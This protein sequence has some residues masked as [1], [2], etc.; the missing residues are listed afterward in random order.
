MSVYAANENGVQALKTMSNALYTAVEEIANHTTHIISITDEYC[1]TIG[2][3]KSSLDQA[4]EE[5]S[6]CIRRSGE[7]ANDIA[8]RLCEVAE[9]Y[10][11]VID[12]DRFNGRNGF[13]N[14]TVGVSNGG[15]FL[16]R[17]FGGSKNSSNVNKFG[18]FDTGKY[19]N[20]DSVVKGDNFEQYMSDYYD[21]EN[22]T[23]E[24]L[25]DN[26]VVETIPPSKIEGIHLGSTEM[27]DNGRFWSQH[28]SGGTADSFKEIASHIPE[29]KAQLDSGRPLND[30]QADPVLG[31]CADIYF[32]PSNIPRV[33][34]SNGYYEFDSN[35]RHRILAARE[36]GYGI[37]VKV[38]GIRT[39]K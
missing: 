13:D 35:G 5:I 28:E 11:E 39:R 4:L 1:D 2:P 27:E 19:K 32:D 21:S 24:S 22:S 25:G 23:Y 26:S 12:N 31:R 34:K 14:N 29:V 33:V 36:L 9:G 17:I 8:E 38:I 6:D 37:P 10:Q 15:S 18:S 20:G 30:I 7:P 3:H 16:G